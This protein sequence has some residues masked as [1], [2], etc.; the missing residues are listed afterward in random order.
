M[1]KLQRPAGTGFAPTIPNLLRHAVEA[2]GARE[3]V[4]DDARTLSYSDVNEASSVIARGL[5]AMG[6]GKAARV[7]LLIPNVVDWVLCWLG[8]ARTGALTQP[9]S[10]LYKPAEIEYCLAHLDVETLFVAERYGSV[11]FVERLEQALPDLRDQKSDTLR[12][13]S[14]PYLRRIVVL[15]ATDR[16]WA[17]KGLD[18]LHLAADDEPRIDDAFLRQVEDRIAPADLLVTISTSGSTAYPKAVVHTHG[19]AVRAPHEFLD[20]IDFQPGERNLASMPMFWVGGL[21]CNLIA[22]MHCG[23]L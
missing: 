22:A 18:S 14:H 9:L 8:A 3:F 2:F 5:L 11:D 23:G 1:Q 16:V 15:G 21:N 7:G 13:P 10:T 20:Y 6:S 19:T 4:A 12:L 17:F